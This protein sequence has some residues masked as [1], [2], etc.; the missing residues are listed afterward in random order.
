[1]SKK[2]RLSL[3]GISLMILMCVGTYFSRGLS[4]IVNDFWFASGL[5]LLI[6]LSLVD[7]P[8]FSKDSNI[9]VNGIT[10]AL[11]L[12]LVAPNER[13]AIYWTFFGVVMYLIISSYILMWLRRKELNLESVTIQTITRINRLIGKPET[14]FSAFFLWGVVRQYGLSSNQFNALLWFWIIFMVLNVPAVANA[15]DSKISTEMA[16]DA[17]N[18][19]GK[20][21]GVQS[22]NTFLV[23]LSEDRKQPLKLFDFVEFFYS[24]DERAHKG[25]VLDV[26]LLDQEQWIKVLTT[27]EIDALFG[28]TVEKYTPDYIYKVIDPPNNNYL[29]RFVGL[30]YQDSVIEKIR[31]SYNAKIDVYSGQLI[32][33]NVGLHKILYQVVQGTTKNE[34]LSSKNESSFIVGEAIQLGEWNIHSGCFEQFGWVPN[35]N[36]PIFLA[37]PIEPPALLENEYIIG[38]IPD[39]NYPVILNKEYAVTH[40]TAILGV[41]GSGKSVFARNMIC[42]IADDN[43]NVI[44]VDLTGEYREKMPGLQSIVTDEEAKDITK[45]IDALAQELA[46]FADKRK[47]EIITDAEK[48]IKLTFNGAIKRF[49]EGEADKIVFELSEISN[50]TSSLEYTRWFFWVLFNTAKYFHNYG[51]RVCVVLEEA[52]TIIPEI[53]SMGVSDNAS[54]A[55]VNSIA[56]I[57][58][59]GRKY[60]I[61]FIVI[62]QRT[63]NVSKT[64][65]TQCNSV[66]VFQELDKT[67]SDFLANYMGRSF[68]DILP[69]LK[70]RTAIAMGKAFRSNSPMIF[71]VPD[72]TEVV[73]QTK[74]EEQ[75]NF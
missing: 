64:V 14:I 36:T 19:I 39:T 29:K 35:V 23:K 16:K 59:Q 21:F 6:L 12:L 46:K 1:M 71:K 42:Q 31:F 30:I 7:Q 15:I 20:I 33:L 49:L 52:H 56:Q 27:S 45:A 63:A 5:L 8:F 68:V 9:F 62:A 4:F 44:I 26:Y 69:T 25:I 48:I 53:S 37:S 17:K 34:Q 3:M 74:D 40:H 54:K 28:Q 65:L 11:S 47:P 58:L 18:A 24:V 50:N 38:N 67:T 32:E 51:K 10:A 75:S 41:T 73:K 66:I 2:Y 70:N 55:T 60:N 61:G 72:I 13:T 57:A 43:T 22:K